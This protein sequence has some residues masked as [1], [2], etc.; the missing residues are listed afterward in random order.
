[1]R[2]DSLTGLL[3]FTERRVFMLKEKLL[4]RLFILIVLI[5][6]CTLSGGFASAEQGIQWKA[7]AMWPPANSLYKA[8]EKFCNNVGVMTKGGL[9][10]KPYPAGAIV[11]NTEALDALKYDTI[12]AMYM[13]AA[14]WAGREP[15]FALLGDLPG[16]W[17]EA[18]EVD[19]FFYEGG[20]LDLLNELYSKYG[21]Y[22]VG[23]SFYGR[24]ESLISTKP[25]GKLTDLKGLKLRAPEGMASRLF[26]KLGASVVVLPASELYTSMD[27][28]LVDG[29]DLST[30]SLNK[31]FGIYPVAKYTVY[32]GWHSLP[33]LDFV[34]NAKAW[35]KLP[36]DIKQIVRTAWREFALDSAEITNLQDVK[37]LP[38]IKKMGV[39]V[40]QWSE[41]DLVKVRKLAREC[42][43]E[44][45]QKSPM[46]KKVYEAYMSW[47]KILGRVE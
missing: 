32:P 7:H 40:Q 38:Q 26:A 14:I 23:V 21:V 42:W 1:M 47:L 33:T 18:W 20:G 44:E 6:F 22:C 25:F 19:S 12:Q 31:D 8:F 43:E 46:A 9:Q 30:L 28:G 2:A 11:P 13:F 3:L 41:E 15:A 16:A 4:K 24:N 10:I 39:T 36:N 5:G 45:A 37:V 29:G 17:S 35:E 34:V 27:K